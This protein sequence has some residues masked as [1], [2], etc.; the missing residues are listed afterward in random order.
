MKNRSITL[1]IVLFSLMLIGIIGIQAWWIKR[2][3]KLNEQAF[4]AAVY[5]SL[6]GVVTQAEKKEN[7]TLIK[8]E[9]GRD[10]ILKVISKNKIAAIKPHK[11]KV[12]ST[13]SFSYSGNLDDNDH[14][15][16][17]V[18]LE[19]GS[20]GK[21]VTIV[22][23]HSGASVISDDGEDEMAKIDLKLQNLDTLL[24]QMVSINSYDSISVKP[25]DIDSI[26]HIQLKQN[27]LTLSHSFALLKNKGVYFYKSHSFKDT[28]D[29]YKV[30]LYPNDVFGRN[31]YLLVHFP[32]KFEQISSGIWW[33]F[34]L[35]LL[36]TL[37]ML[38]LFIY[39]IRMLIQHK[40]LLLA[41]NDFISHMSHEFKTPLAGISIGADMIAEKGDKMTLD[42]ITKVAHSIKEQST[43]LNKDVSSILLSA[44]VDEKQNP[45][46]QPFD[47]VDV[48]KEELDAF[49]FLLNSLIAKV[50]TSFPTEKTM[51]VGDRMLWQK[52]IANL[53]DNSLKFSKETPLITIRITEFAP[54]KLIL[55]FS[56]NAVG[57]S[58]EDLPHIF[59]KFYR[60]DYQNKSNIQGFG[61]GLS[62]V[63]K[64]VDMHG[65][66][67]KA[68]SEPGKGTTMLIEI[69]KADV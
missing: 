8:K 3:L 37:I 61:L 26:L 48:I 17:S 63:K 68:S 58:R 12:Y 52:V 31:M 69:N 45:I 44:M 23:N 41:K 42:Q 32:G 20:N 11:T 49:K 51:I 62:F 16:A 39:S 57:I 56:D 18:K 5:R 28:I 1:I 14:G 25:S 53:L 7:Y 66:T 4:D 2:S 50:E 19:I 21:K 24:K 10:S 29:I 38:A 65:G 54:N 36:F 60:S 13:E 35:S 59:E 9:F 67:I 47:I 15:N 43:R 27:N 55:E 46:K 6:Q 40:N 30:N 22:S 33:A 34:I 64:V